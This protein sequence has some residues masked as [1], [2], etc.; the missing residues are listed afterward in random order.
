MT[1]RLRFFLLALLALLLLSG[2]GAYWAW[3]T[4]QAAGPLD[5]SK[6][7][8]IPPRSSTQDIAERLR[9]QGVTSVNDT[10]FA[11]AAWLTRRQGPLRAGEYQ[12]PA[13]AS[14]AATLDVLRTAKPVQRL[15]TIPEGLSAEQITAL[16][17]AAP[18]LTG[19]AP[20]LEEAQILPD[21]YAY[22]WGDTR[23]SVVQRGTRALRQFLAEAWDKRQD[24]LPF[25]TPRDALVLA[26]IVERETGRPD[27]RAHV[28]G[29]F[30]GRLRLGM[31]LQSDPTVAYASNN[32]KALDRALTRADLERDHPFNTYRNRGL[33]PGPIAAPGRDAIQAVL[34]PAQTDDLYFVANGEGGHSF[35]RTLDEHNRNVQRWRARLQ[36]R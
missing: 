27:E 19:D 32:G 23:A 4:Y 33:P 3:R 28:A 30:I 18:G 11:A 34:H 35:A 22:E 12:F 36:P 10:G 16:L 13:H 26:S 9:E 21:T 5:V 14:V 15:L 6:A 2:G 8:V 1:R 25:T 7:V 20:V 24:G 31:P 29:V 17:Q